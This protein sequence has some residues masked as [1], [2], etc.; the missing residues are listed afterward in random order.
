MVD[1]VI[2][3]AERRR[4]WLAAAS[5]SPRRSSDAADEDADDFD[6]DRFAVR[7]GAETLAGEREQDEK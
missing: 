5:G 2:R 7:H 1:A 3:V 6:G 4:E